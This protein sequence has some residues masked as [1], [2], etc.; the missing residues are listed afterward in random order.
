LLYTAFDGL[1]I[2]NM[3]GSEP[4]IF[5]N[6]P[7]LCA[8]W[9]PDGNQVVYAAISSSSSQQVA[10]VNADGSGA[11]PVVDDGVR[12]GRPEWSP[13]GEWISYCN[14]ANPGGQ[15]LWMIRPDSTE[16]HGVTVSEVIGYPDYQTITTGPHSWAPD[17]TRLAVAFLAQAPDQPDLWG[18]GI[19]GRDGGALK[20]IFIAPPG[21]VCCAAPSLPRWSPDGTKILF[22]SAHHLAV[23]PDWGHGKLELGVELWLINADGSGEPT[24]LTYDQSFNGPATWWGPDLFEDVPKGQWAYCAIS[25]CN[26][27]GIV[28]GYS[29]GTYKPTNPVTRDQMAVYISRALAGGDDGVPTGPA[30]ATFPDVPT[31]YWAFKYVEYAV[32]E[33]VVKGYSD[34][35]YKPTDQVDR[36]QMAVFIARSIYTPTAARLD[37]IG[38]TPPTTATF[39]DVP[40]SFWAYKYVEYIAQPAIAVTKGYPD[41]DYHPE[42][43]CTRDQMAVY[44]A[45]AL[46]LPM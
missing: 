31:D 28:Q 42:Y 14:E 23:D 4:T 34:G 10:V 6:V 3:D 24:R 40:T 8:R 45:R 37:L 27:A 2:D 33:N 36:G 22:S 18:V 15:A 20:P 17:A 12:L 29:D 35:T 25:A 30:T 11:H 1:A 5:P 16:K 21:V 26:L 38:Y 13:D 32:T 41:G 44:V 19:I 46:R 7:S 43:I 9:S 39:P